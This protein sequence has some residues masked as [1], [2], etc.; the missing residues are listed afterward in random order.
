[1]IGSDELVIGPPAAVGG[2]G[3]GKGEG[4]DAGLGQQVLL[5]EGLGLLA[6]GDDGG[7]L[8]IACEKA[9]HIVGAYIGDGVI[10]GAI[11]AAFCEHVPEGNVVAMGKLLGGFW[12]SWDFLLPEGRQGAPEAILWVA[13]I[14]IAFARFWRGHGAE[15]E[16]TAFLIYPGDEGVGDMLTHG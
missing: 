4:L 14:H 8:W 2:G 16:H 9:G 10:G 5:V 12:G 1:M 7:N 3:G 15:H 6:G 11:D 13:I